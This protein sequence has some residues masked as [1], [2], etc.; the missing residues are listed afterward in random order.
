MQRYL[1]KRLALAVV[2]LLVVSVIIFAMSRA[3]GDPRHVYLDDYSTQADWDRLTVALGLDKPYYVQYGIFLGD[4]LRGNFGQSIKERRPVLE[5]II[6]R[7]PATFQLGTAAFLFSVVVGLPLGILSAVKRGSTLDVSGKILALVGQS[8]PVFWLG[9]M[10]MF[11][12]AVKLQWLPP[13]G[14]QE[15]VSIVLPAVT[16]GWFYVAANLRLIRSGMLDVLDSE[17]IKLARAK[18]VSSNVVVWKHAL[19]NAVIPAL[20]FAGVTLGA[21]VTGSIV[22][23]QV[24]AWP[25]LG[26]LAIEALFGSDYPLLQGV[27]IVF[28]L[29]YVA[30]SLTVDILYAYIDPRIRYG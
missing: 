27:V 24:F 18:G 3:A 8:A 12:F 13:Y 6:E 30:A 29:L 23:E 10:L 1:F 28:T 19:R 4:A 7:I 21:L 11:L 5:V 2:T 16:L 20:T 26:R 14:R 17:Y 9:I 22:V 15:G 25:G